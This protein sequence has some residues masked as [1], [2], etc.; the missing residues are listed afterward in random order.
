MQWFA[1][2]PEEVEHIKDLR[3]L[4]EEQKTLIRTIVHELAHDLQPLVT[5]ATNNVSPLRPDIISA[6]KSAA[7]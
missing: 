6:I 7:G 4:S 5:V 2:Q 3:A 1:L